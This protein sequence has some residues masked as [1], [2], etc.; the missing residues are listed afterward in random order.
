MTEANYLPPANISQEAIAKLRLAVGDDTLDIDFNIDEP[1]KP[2]V[3]FQSAVQEVVKARMKQPHT[4]DKVPLSVA[5]DKYLERK[6]I[7]R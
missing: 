1:Y 4:R 6:R 5:I 3:A 2:S 7:T